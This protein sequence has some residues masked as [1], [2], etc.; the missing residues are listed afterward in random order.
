MQAT[1]ALTKLSLIIFTSIYNLSRN[2]KY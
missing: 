1:F 2:P